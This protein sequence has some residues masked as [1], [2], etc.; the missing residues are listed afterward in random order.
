MEEDKEE[1]KE[2]P[3]RPLKLARWGVGEVNPRDVLVA[4]AASKYIFT[5]GVSVDRA[6]M[7]QIQVLFFCM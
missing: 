5:Y 7:R 6:A 1:E 4:Q 2:T 3:F